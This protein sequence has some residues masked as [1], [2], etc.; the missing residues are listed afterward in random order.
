M[1]TGILVLKKLL[2]SILIFL[3]ADN[4]VSGREMMM[5]WTLDSE[6]WFLTNA[7]LTD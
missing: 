1:F 2:L 7:E 6:V 4:T 5:F 3:E